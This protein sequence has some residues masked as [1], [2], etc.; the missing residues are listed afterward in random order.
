M[1]FQ[2]CDFEK[3]HVFC[4]G[5]RLK[6]ESVCKKCSSERADR[7]GKR[8]AFFY[9][10]LIFQIMSKGGTIERFSKRF[11]GYSIWLFFYQAQLSSAKLVL[12]L[13][14]LSPSLCLLFS[15]PFQNHRRDCHRILN[16]CM[17]SQNPK[18]GGFAS[19]NKSG[20]PPTPQMGVSSLIGW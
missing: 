12:S 19:K 20:D 18:L 2:N 10:G 1:N 11:L 8:W 7:S 13:A 9:F 3:G 17:S 5:V 16:F 4:W 14:Q 15:A 6:S